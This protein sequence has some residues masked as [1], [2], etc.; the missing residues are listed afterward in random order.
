VVKVA[1]GAVDVKLI[2]AR[3]Y[4][5]ILLPAPGREPDPVSA[6]ILFYLETTVRMRLDKWEGMGESTWAQGSVVEAT[7]DG[8][9][10][11]LRTK[12]LKGDIHTIVIDDFAERLK[13][14]TEDELKILLR[15]YLDKHAEPGPSDSAAISSHL[16]DHV[17]DVYTVIHRLETE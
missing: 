14:L 3:G 1:E 9:F 2:T 16:D 8:L 7:T 10:Q 12:E 6:L 15:S 11:A 4:E 17:R 13:A 5:P